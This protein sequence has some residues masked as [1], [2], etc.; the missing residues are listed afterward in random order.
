MIISFHAR[1]GGT[2]IRILIAGLL[3]VA[4]GCRSFR[5]ELKD[6]AQEKEYFIPVNF[7]GERQLPAGLRRVLVLPVYGGRVAGVESAQT[8]DDVLLSALQKTA[9]FEVVTL[10]RTE[11]QRRFSR[12][13]FS[14]SSELPNG[15]LTELGRAYGA[16]AVL[17]VDLTLYEPYRPLAVGFRAKLAVI[18]DV[19]IIWTFDESFSTAD[20]AVVNSAQRFSRK[21]SAAKVPVDM[22]VGTLQSPR[23]FAAYAAEAMFDTLPPR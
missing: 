20:R 23:R 11:C 4:T 22:T 21:G 19:R 17:F 15:F 7:N 5:E 13:E 12:P 6:Q 18:Q 9:R 8:L 1:Q 16:E 2:V 10:S 3:L 14:S